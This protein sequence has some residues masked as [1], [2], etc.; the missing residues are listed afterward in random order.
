MASHGDTRILKGPWLSQNLDYVNPISEPTAEKGQAPVENRHARKVQSPPAKHVPLFLF[1][2]FDTTAM[3][4][5][6]K[7]RK[8]LQI[9]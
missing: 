9:S 8:A 4:G 5:S 2:L 7:P 6:N 3:P 1:R